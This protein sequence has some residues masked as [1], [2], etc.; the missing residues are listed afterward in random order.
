MTT[1]QLKKIMNMVE[2]NDNIEILILDKDGKQ[3]KVGNIAVN[4][5]NKQISLEMVD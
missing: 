5:W 4:P 3:H 1:K 2:P